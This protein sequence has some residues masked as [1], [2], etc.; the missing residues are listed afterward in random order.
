MRPM[1]ASA[2][3][4]RAGPKSPPHRLQ[5]R[6]RPGTRL[7]NLLPTLL[8]LL[9]ACSPEPPEIERSPDVVAD[10]TRYYIDSDPERIFAARFLGV[11]AFQNPAD[12]W[13]MQEILAE[14]RPDF[15]VECGTGYGGS[16]LFF[17]LIL[18]QVNPAGKVITI[19]LKPGIEGAVEALKDR[20]EL[21]RQ[22]QALLRQRVEVVTS[23]TLDPGLLS[24]LR[25]RL[26]GR[27]V[28]VTLDSCHNVDHV[29]REIEAY[30]PMV[31]VGGYLIVQDTIIDERPEWIARFGRCPGYTATG[32]PGLAVRR[33]LAE[34]TDFV[35]DRSREKFLLTFYPA[36]Y[37]RRIR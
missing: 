24:R 25:R 31:S 10:F 26:Q 28:I 11:P 22:V 23:D 33:F 19:D 34:R 3:V 8:F 18:Q 36:G 35:S 14:V 29:S 37:L 15:V 21:Y 32:G 30:A 27:R 5:A 4:P 20:P 7:V 2:A 17:A 12:L 13:A 16:A 1:G 9:A 6:T